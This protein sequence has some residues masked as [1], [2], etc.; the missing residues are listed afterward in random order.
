MQEELLVKKITLEK[1]EAYLSEFATKSSCFKGRLKYEEPCPM[2]T[3][4]QRDRDRIIY[5]LAFIRLKNK[6]QVFFSPEGDHYMTRLTHTLDVSQIARSIARCLSLNEDLTEA[7]ALGHDLGHTPFG[8]A[9][10]RVLNKL[11]PNGFKHNEQSLRV[12][13][14]LEKGGVG[15]N[16]TYEVRDGILNH[17]SNTKPSTLEGQA[18]NV[19]DRIAYLNHDVDDAV[20]AGV[21][22]ESDLPKN[23]VEILGKTS[24]ERI[25]KMIT[26]AYEESAGKNYV[27]LAPD[28]DKAMTELRN[29]MF[30]NVYM[31]PIAKR[32][33]ERANNMLTAMYEYFIK[34]PETL[35]EFY[36]K[37]LNEYSLETV[38]CDYLS[39][40]TDRYAIS[41]FRQIFVPESF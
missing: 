36:K 21:I 12:V 23:V 28:V 27:K 10:E 3:P 33:E 32:E 1:E 39:G 30:E 6:T 5:S 9:G 16:L 2:R 7:I 26:S 18:V 41:A 25:N 40:M 13:D 34:A 37:L 15:L 24:R 14:V 29:F 35:P 38:I 4:F 31:M 22:A 8:H 17:K 19:S 11:S 20:R